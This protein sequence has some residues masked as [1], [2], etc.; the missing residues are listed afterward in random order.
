VYHVKSVTPCSCSFMV[1]RTC[2]CSVCSLDRLLLVFLEAIGQ[3]CSSF[4]VRFRSTKN[5]LY[6]GSRISL[7]LLC[8]KAT[9]IYTSRVSLPS[10]RPA[11]HHVSR[12]LAPQLLLFPANAA[13]RMPSTTTS[14]SSPLQ[15]HLQQTIQSPK[16]HSCSPCP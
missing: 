3:R 8:R 9:P 4:A 10:C 15:D 5:G 6:A 12:C 13:P 11:I 1:R 7:Q 16:P 2:F 14:P